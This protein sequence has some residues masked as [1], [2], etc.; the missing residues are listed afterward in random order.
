MLEAMLESQVKALPMAP[1]DDMND[2]GWPREPGVFSAWSRSALAVLGV[3]VLLANAP[4]ACACGYH[5]PSKLGLGMINWAYPDA[6]HVRTAVWMAQRDGVLERAPIPIAD[7]PTS[8][9]HRFQQALRLREVQMQLDGLRAALARGRGEASPPGFALLL[10]GPLLWAR[11]EPV[12]D[13]LHLQPHAAGP[14]PGD[15]V[16]VSDEPVLAALVGGRLSPHAARERGLL[17][18]YG[19][20]P[21]SEQVAAWLDRLDASVQEPTPPQIR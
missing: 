18:L 15:V 14:A 13:T 11:F 9:N 1:H 16:V 17:R 19:S 7:D 5:D 20:A 3:T 12:D 4:S 10:M 2:G 21:A 8:A 6:L